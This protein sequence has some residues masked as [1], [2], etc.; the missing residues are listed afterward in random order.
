MGN[1]PLSRSSAHVYAGPLRQSFSPTLLA[2][3]RLHGYGT[4]DPGVHFGISGFA[5]APRPA[6]QRTRTVASHFSLTP[7]RVVLH[8]QG[9]SSPSP[10]SRHLAGGF[11]ACNMSIINST[12]SP[13]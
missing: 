6:R 12:S 2:S 8:I 10:F 13:S 4:P 11:S 1:H 9:F 5:P 7:L 3:R